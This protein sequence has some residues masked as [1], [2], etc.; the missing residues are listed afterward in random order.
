MSRKLTWAMMIVGFGL[1]HLV[2]MRW[3][4]PIS[5]NEFL[6]AGYWSAACFFVH[7]LSQRRTL[8][9]IESPPVDSATLASASR[10]NKQG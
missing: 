3:V 2:F 1:Y 8:P 6:A 4:R 9:V 5:L 10:E 7:W